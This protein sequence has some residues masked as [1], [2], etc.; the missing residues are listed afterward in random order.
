MER[1]QILSSGRSGF[2]HLTGDFVAERL[3]V[4]AAIGDHDLN[5]HLR[6]RATG[7]LR[8]ASVLVPLIDRPAGLT[9]LLTER[10]QHLTNHAGQIA[11]PGGRQEPEDVDEIDAALRETEEEIG[12][13]RA[14]VRVIGRL[15]TC[16]TG[17]L[18]S[19]TP[20]VGL[21]RPPFP[22]RPDPHEVA[23]VFEVPLSFIADPAHHERRSRDYEG[24]PRYF[25]V[26]PFEQRYIWG[27][28][29]GMLVNLARRLADPT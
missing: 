7:T 28:T 20:I 6:G 13:P 16:V 3:S 10:T 23:D 21:I 24:R 9:V 19:I 2:S 27:A 26:L 4:S 1:R 22:L 15:D 5:P 25:Y 18:Y 17:T 12:L 8:H 14:F 11:F 29:A